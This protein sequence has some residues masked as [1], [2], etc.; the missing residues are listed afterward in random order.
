[1]DLKLAGKR[2]LV[3]GA[4][5]GIGRGIALALAAEGVRLALTARSEDGL[6]ETATQVAALGAPAPVCIA[7]DL[8]TADGI[9]RIVDEAGRAL[10]AVEVLVNNAGGSR[11]VPPDA[12]DKFWDESF[13]LNF[14][15]ARRLTD[16]LLPAMRQAKWGRIVN[17]T[18]AIAWKTM[19]AAQPAKAALLSWSRGL[20]GDV[21]RDGVTVNCIAPGR[22]ESVQIM[23][24][25][26]PTEEARR[27]FIDQ[28]IPMG[29]FGQPA[30]IA[31]LVAFLVSPLAGYITA[32]SI[33]VDGGLYRLDLK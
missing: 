20:A 8:T 6:R 26:H 22:I 4:G 14:T 27:A 33:P 30:D 28:N 11:P 24:R 16:A 25:L 3:T 1:M 21:A 7:A 29:R 9:A 13:A 23:T 17:I 10:G 12:D 31:N 19:N 5:A 18:G 32:A 15:A 2:C